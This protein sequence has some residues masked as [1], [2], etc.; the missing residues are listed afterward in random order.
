MSANYS[1]AT[2]R[3]TYQP[4]II[5]QKLLLSRLAIQLAF[6]RDECKRDPRGFAMRLAQDLLTNPRIILAFVVGTVVLAVVMRSTIEKPHANAASADEPGPDVVLYDVNRLGY[7]GFN[8]GTGAGSGPIRR[9]A[10]G[11]GGSGNHDPDPPQL[12]KLPPPSTLLA[13][14]P[15][16]PPIAAPALPMAGIKID[17]A[18]WKDLKDPVYGD[19]TSTATKP[20]PGPGEGEGIGTGKGL[21][22]GAGEGAGVGPGW[23]ENTGGGYG[24]NGCCGEGGGGGAAGGYGGYG[25]SFTSREVDQRARVLSKPEPQYTEEARRNQIVGTVVLRAVFS[26][27]GEVVQIQALNTLPFGLTERAI[28]AARQIKFVPAMKGGRPVSVLMQLEYNFNLY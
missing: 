2:H 4:T 15:L 27:D 8:D 7:A 1:N 5:E 6:V 23:K 17:P 9:P 25:Q 11:G 28:A 19:P 24:M 26:R 22:I 21:G 3:Y 18:L 16:V 14:I 20:S 13:P 10:H 12:G